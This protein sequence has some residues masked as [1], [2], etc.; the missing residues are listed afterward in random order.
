[1]GGMGI[2]A[3]VGRQLSAKHKQ[4][5]ALILERYRQQDQERRAKAEEGAYDR[6]S[7]DS[8]SDETDREEGY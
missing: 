1:M 5:A 6:H 2:G 8:S 7:S 3:Y 4:D